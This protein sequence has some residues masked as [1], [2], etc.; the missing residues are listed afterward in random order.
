MKKIWFLLIVIALGGCK[1]SNETNEEE[2]G[3]YDY[4]FQTVIE[5]KRGIDYD[6]FYGTTPDSDDYIL[7]EGLSSYTFER[8]IKVKDNVDGVAEIEVDNDTECYLRVHEGSN[9]EY[10]VI[11]FSCKNVRHITINKSGCIEILPTVL[12]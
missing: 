8:T 12:W 10:T 1:M 6:F 9:Q 2:D 11:K 7:I 4:T 5:N 3:L